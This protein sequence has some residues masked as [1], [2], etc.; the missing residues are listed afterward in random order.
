VSIAF[1]P[2]VRL[3]SRDAER[4]SDD[5]SNRARIQCGARPGTMRPSHLFDLTPEVE[6]LLSS[7]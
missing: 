2:D 7:A 1:Q 5:R 3:D 6:Q 4:Y